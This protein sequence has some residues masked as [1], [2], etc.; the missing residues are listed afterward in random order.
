MRAKGFKFC[1]RIIRLFTVA[2]ATRIQLS[3]GLS[4]IK[5][6]VLLRGP[7]RAEVIDR[8]TGFCSAG[9]M[10]RLQA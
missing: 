3:A 7:A 9:T 8:L 5:E 2:T 6:R 10:L 1:Q 4:G